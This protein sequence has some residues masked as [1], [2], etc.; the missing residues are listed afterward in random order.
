M[1]YIKINFTEMRYKDPQ[2]HYRVN[3]GLPSGQKSRTKH[4]QARLQVLKEKRNDQQ[5]EKLA[6]NNQCNP[7]KIYEN[8]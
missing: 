6:R 7:K 3:I 4:L 1:F 8:L 2:L 5:L